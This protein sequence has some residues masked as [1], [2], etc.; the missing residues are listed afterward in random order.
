[1]SRILR[2]GKAYPLRRAIVK[3]RP[4]S[5]TNHPRITA[6]VAFVSAIA[7]AAAFLQAPAAHAA[8]VVTSGAWTYDLAGSE[9]TITGYDSDL[10][11]RADVSTPARI[12]SY[13]V[14]GIGAGAFSGKSLTGHFTMPDTI[15]TIGNFAFGN[16]DL[17]SIHLSNSL[18]VIGERAFSDNRRLASIVLPYGVTSIGDNAFYGNTSLTTVASLSPTPPTIAAEPFG[19]TPGGIAPDRVPA[20]QIQVST[21]AAEAWGP[22]FGGLDVTGTECVNTSGGAFA[23]GSGTAGSPYTIASPA[24]LDSIRSI[25]RGC[26]FE[27]TTDISLQP[28]IDDYARGSWGPIGSYSEP[29]TG[30]F[31]G[32]NHSITNLK[33]TGTRS[34]VGLFGTTSGATISDLR[35]SGN[36][37]GRLLVG[38]LI[39]EANTTTVTHVSAAVEM[40]STLG[41]IGGLIGSALDVSI[42]KSSASGNISMA[43]GQEYG[44][45]LVGEYVSNAPGVHISQSFASGNVA[46]VRSSGLGTR[47]VGGLIGSIGAMDPSSATTITDVYATGDVSGDGQ[48][49]GLIGSAGLTTITRAFATGINNSHDGSGG[50]IGLT[51]VVPIDVAVT[52]SYWDSERTRYDNS[53][54]YGDAADWGTHV[55][56]GGPRTTAQMKNIATYAS[57]SWN[58]TASAWSDTAVW[59]ICAE[60]NGGYP[61][62][63]AFHTA[64]AHPC[65]G[66]TPS[67]PVAPGDTPSTLTEVTQALVPTLAVTPVVTSPVLTSTPAVGTTPQF[68]KIS[69]STPATLKTALAQL[70]RS[71]PANN[72]VTYSIPLMYQKNCTIR[73]GKIV[74]LKAGTCGIRVT[75]T[76][77]K[78]KQTHQRAYL[79]VT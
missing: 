49:G 16:N 7:I 5:V 45:G 72:T 65:S 32:A 12:D 31:D 52:S 67:S 77:V 15:T 9:A 10:G 2:R 79:T 73:E 38:G 18:N 30:N 58:I 69:A 54:P 11:G 43:A 68:P 64:A 24:Q 50:L 56:A 46:G 26:D 55:G 63:L 36:V 21:A 29:F 60:A 23:G 25:F 75:S 47:Y 78:G 17:V 13:V 40:T 70:S 22:N 37:T 28:Y 41:I 3:L 39:G 44:G 34:R 53:A 4:S 33:V 8:P 1:M 19:Y 59:G 71:V 51:P 57:S 42:E 66:P 74:A 61:Y 48:V 62:L 20:T 14:T 35:V 76:S 6:K 27:L